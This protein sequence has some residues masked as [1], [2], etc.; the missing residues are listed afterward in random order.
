MTTLAPVAFELEGFKSPASVAKT[1][2]QKRLEQHS[3]KTPCSPANLEEKL[4]KGEEA[5]KVR[6]WTRHDPGVRSAEHRRACNKLNRVLCMARP[7]CALRV[8]AW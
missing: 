2:V 4:A 1:P 6:V 5:R 3:P 7:S 8:D